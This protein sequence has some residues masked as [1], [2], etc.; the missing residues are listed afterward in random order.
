MNIEYVKNCVYANIE[1][2]II[3]CTV[4]FAE[5][6]EEHP[7]SANEN[8]PAKHGREIYARIIAGEFG[9]IAPY[10][11]PVITTE[12]KA[13]RVRDQRG[14]LLGQMDAVISNPLRWASMTSEQQAAWTTY[15]QALL[16]VPQQAGFPD[17]INWP[18]APTP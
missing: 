13:Y 17:N 18:V 11:A 8:D 4:K 6:N 16:D 5:F 3:N 9:T 7:F 12:M 2:T 15:R 14:Q 10:V 1:S